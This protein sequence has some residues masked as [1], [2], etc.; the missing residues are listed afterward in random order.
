MTLL[1]SL[2]QCLTAL[3]SPRIVAIGDL[4]GD[5][6]S[7]RHVLELAG[8]VDDAGHWIA[9][10]TILVQTGDITDKGPSS[11]G[12][13]RL[14]MN[15][16]A[17]ATAAGGRVV[18]LL[19]NHEV[20]N[21]QGDL[22]YVRPEDFE[23]FGGPAS[24][25]AAF[26]ESGDLGRWLRARDAVA[27]VDGNLFVHGG[28]S[29][30]F[31]QHSPEALSRMTRDGIDGADPQR[32]LGREGPLWYRGYFLA[33]EALACRELD[34]VLAQQGAKRMIVGHT[35][36]RTG[37]IGVRCGGRLIGIDTGLSRFYGQH[38]AALEIS[39]DDAAA[40]YPS[41]KVD[42]PDPPASPDEDGTRGASTR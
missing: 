24:R 4:H 2:L 26:A 28:V 20:M 36:Q 11:N 37:H 10:E 9:G 27:L 31:A 7:S 3:A 33:D 41:G 30:R 13:I 15:L 39:E 29:H 38:L 21:L 23:E 16:E 17:E 8:I 40:I 25:Q 34:G 19:G 6:Q 35:V 12:V 42:L 5:V 14:L 18:A 32:V 22:R 1:L